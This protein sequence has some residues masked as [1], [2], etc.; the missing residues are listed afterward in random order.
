MITAH[1]SVSMAAEKYVKAA[2]CQ[3]KNLELKDYQLLVLDRLGV[4]AIKTARFAETFAKGGYLSE[5]QR[6]LDRANESL[7]AFGDYAEKIGVNCAE[8]SIE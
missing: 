3:A 5:S 2:I 8:L 4:V 6:W 1:N 7:I